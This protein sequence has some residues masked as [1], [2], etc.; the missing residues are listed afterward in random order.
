M[1]AKNAE[2]T[3]L[4]KRPAMQYDLREYGRHDYVANACLRVVA[5][6]TR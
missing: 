1:T 2:I 3:S 4:R 5:M 6:V